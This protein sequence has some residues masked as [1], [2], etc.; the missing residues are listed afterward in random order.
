MKQKLI[1][2]FVGIIVTAALLA[3]YSSAFAQTYQTPSTSCADGYTLVGGKCVIKN[4][5]PEYLVNTSSFGDLLRSVINI[6]LIF[7][8]AIAVLFLI[9]G[10]YKYIIS[11]GND[12]GMESAKKTIS[13]ALIGIIII[14]MAY[15]IIAIVNNLLTRL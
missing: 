9:V 4:P 3:G 12:E 15:A 10:G 13:G 14:V 6:A 5:A 11:R 7:A 8:G 2:T 1:Y